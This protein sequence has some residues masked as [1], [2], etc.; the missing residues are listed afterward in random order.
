MEKLPQLPL[1]LLELSP[2]KIHRVYPDRHIST[3][4]LLTYK[5][6]IKVENNVSLHRT[7]GKNSAGKEKI[8]IQN[9]LTN[10]STV[11]FYQR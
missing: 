11:C 1:T 7:S 5:P 3:T 2:E 6:R 8:S 10:L 4:Q 9:M